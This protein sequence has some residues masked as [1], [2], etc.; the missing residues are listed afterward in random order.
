MKR[1]FQNNGGLILVAA[2]LLAAV[3]ALGSS[4]LGFD[5][6][7]DL[8]EVIA[9][10]FRAASTAVTNW[11]GDWYDRSFRYAELEAENEALRLQVAELLAAAL[12]GQ[13][14]QRENE[15]LRD[16]LG[17][18]LERPEL[19]YEDAAVTRRSTSNW[20]CDLT[21]DKGTADGV[22]VNNCVIDQ[23]GSLVGVV[24]EAGANWAL[25]TAVIDPD[26]EL[27]GRIARTD[28]DA[29]VEGS[30]ALMLEGLLKLSYLPEDA[31]L[32]SGD[33]VITS[34]LGGVYPAGLLVGS[35]RGVYTEEDG[36]SRY[37]EVEPAADVANVKYV[38]VITDYGGE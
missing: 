22:A 13:D 23:Y 24:T 32:V 17:L 16:L 6:V 28:D 3:L 7:T 25:V 5:P 31:Q 20:T 8:A 30:F 1:F 34:G 27:G 38:Y 4:I 35:I 19:T 37:A 14:A 2:I 21:I 15:R 26:L 11:A 33:Q 18:A 29:I 10:P 9:T 12:E 36:M